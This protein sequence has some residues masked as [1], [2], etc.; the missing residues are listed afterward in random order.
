MATCPPSLILALSR[1]G[2]LLPK[3]II[4]FQPSVNGS[5]TWHTLIATYQIHAL[6]LGQP[7][8][9]LLSNFIGE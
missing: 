4:F 5:G 6:T 9:D 1:A 8:A 2:V 3:V 7:A